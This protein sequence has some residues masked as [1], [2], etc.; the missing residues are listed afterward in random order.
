VKIEHYK[1]GSS[2][3]GVTYGQWTVQWW[4]WALSI[5]SSRNPVLDE[6]GKNAAI[7]QPKDVWF[8]A[9]IFAEA[10]EIRKFPSR[11]CS[12]PTGT[13]ILIPILNCAADTI[14]YPEL[15]SDEDILNHLSKQVQKVLRKECYI[16]NEP[17]EAERVASDPR[18]FDLYVHPDFD[19]FAKGGNARAS[20]DG[21][22]VFL[23]PLPKGQYIVEFVGEYVNRELRSGAKYTINIR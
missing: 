22:W 8:L 14:H 2:H 20:A 10:N 5:S 6:I 15:E 16:N 23:K 9:G 4:R 3:C 12:I 1:S 17:I 13:H 11:E 19:K 18:I 7:G 21:Y